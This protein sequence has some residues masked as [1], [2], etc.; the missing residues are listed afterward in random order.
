LKK[1][2]LKAIAN[3]RRFRYDK[4]KT[5]YVGKFKVI[6]LNPLNKKIDYTIGGSNITVNDVLF[7][8]DSITIITIDQSDTAQLVSKQYKIGKFDVVVSTSSGE[9]MTV[10]L[11]NDDE[12]MVNEK[13]FIIS[14][15]TLIKIENEQ[16]SVHFPDFNLSWL[17]I[18]SSVRKI[19]KLEI[20]HAPRTIR[21]IYLIISSLLTLAIIY[22]VVSFI[23]RILFAQ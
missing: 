18:F 19:A 8:I 22:I 17:K 5:I 1:A 14:K 16:T 2:I 12:I 6:I 9:E 20:K 10:K 3:W 21:L 4:A 13:K 23:L 15:D 11:S 7:S